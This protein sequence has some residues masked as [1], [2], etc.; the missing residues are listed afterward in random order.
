MIID[1][2]IIPDR[3]HTLIT[4]MEM[5]DSDTDRH[6]RRIRYYVGL[7]LQ[8]VKDHVPEYDLTEEQME[9]IILASSLQDLGK[10]TI[11]D[12]VRNKAGAFSEPEYE[13][14]KMHTVKGEQIVDTIP[15]D[16][17]PALKEYCKQICRHH[18]ERYDGSGFPD[19]LRG[20]EIPL[21]AQV[22]SV[23]EVFDLMTT[24]HFYRRSCKP[25][26][27]YEMIV[28]GKAGAFSPTLLRCMQ[29]IQDEMMEY[30]SSENTR[31]DQ[32]N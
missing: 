22:V 14:Y 20:E 30:A 2:T 4:I 5:C 18:H 11:P 24:D 15:A 23:A 17:D 21:A 9:K 6:I 29:Y 10:I 19:G 25:A 26:Q 3:I 12:I 8:A 28:S 16:E 32:V 7:L 13:I 31:K 27:A 1:D